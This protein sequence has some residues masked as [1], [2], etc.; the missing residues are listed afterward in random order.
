MSQKTNFSYSIACRAGYQGAHY[1]VIDQAGTEKLATGNTCISVKH[2]VNRWSDQ[3]IGTW[4]VR[5]MKQVSKL[6]TICREL[7]RK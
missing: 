6:G 1:P 7:D 4:I 3:R 2:V 5:K